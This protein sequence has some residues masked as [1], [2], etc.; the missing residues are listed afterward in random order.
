MESASI[1][2]CVQKL[3]YTIEE[4]VGCRLLVACNCPKC[5][6]LATSSVLRQ[7]DTPAETLQVSQVVPGLN[8]YKKQPS[9][10]PIIPPAHGQLLHLTESEQSGTA[11]KRRF[12]LPRR[13]A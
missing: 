11:G 13:F 2:H 9:Q 7:N 8:K 1:R 5:W 10:V 3:N 4:S 6:K 12:N